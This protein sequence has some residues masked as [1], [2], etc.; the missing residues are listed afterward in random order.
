VGLIFASS[1]LWLPPTAGASRDFARIRQGGVLLLAMCF[2]GIVLLILFRLKSETIIPWAEAR[3]NDWP[4]VPIKV[5][6]ALIGFVD[7]LARALRILANARELAVTIGWTAILWGSI[8]FANLLV[9]RAFHLQVG[10]LQIGLTDALFV[11]GFSMV[12][13]AVP[14]P[15]GAAGAFHA[16]T[17]AGL[18]FLGIAKEQAAAVVI[19][20]HLVDFGPGAVFGLFYFLRG[21]ISL[22]RLRELMKP[23]A[24]EHAVEDEKIVPVKTLD[25]TKLETA[26]AR[27]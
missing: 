6:R 8:A 1:L 27:E 21:E 7:Q 20:L 25:K 23:E 24:V 3:L 19:V 12:G 17:A 22:A 11:L 16:A 18:I 10:G 13:S 26:G 2:A 15:G 5:K 4:R 9:F 14:T